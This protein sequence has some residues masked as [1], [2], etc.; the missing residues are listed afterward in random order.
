MERASL[1]AFFTLMPLTAALVLTAIW[2]NGDHTWPAALLKLIPTAFVLGFA[3]F[4]TWFTCIL[5][6]MAEC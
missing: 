3:S 6:R 5:R 2:T 1:R 4:L